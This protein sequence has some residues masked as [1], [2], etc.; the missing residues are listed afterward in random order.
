MGCLASVFLPF[1]QITTVFVAYIVGH[2]LQSLWRFIAKL[3]RFHH[4]IEILIPKVINRSLAFRKRYLV[5]AC[6]S[7]VSGDRT[8]P[9]RPR[10]LAYRRADFQEYLRRQSASILSNSCSISTKSR[11]FPEVRKIVRIGSAGR[12]RTST[13]SFLTDFVRALCLESRLICHYRPLF[14][15]TISVLSPDSFPDT[16]ALNLPKTIGCKKRGR[17]STSTKKAVLAGTE[18]L[19]VFPFMS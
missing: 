1:L 17:L 2:F 9:L 14:R 10:R 3:R 8:R 18:H 19:G 13:S 16:H 6:Q 15:R 4:P 11:Y 12:T 7:T 5:D